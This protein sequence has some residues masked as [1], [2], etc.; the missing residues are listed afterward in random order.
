MFSVSF[1]S[2]FKGLAL[3]RSE[4]SDRSER[5]ADRLIRW[6]VF[7]TGAAKKT[8]EDEESKEHRFQL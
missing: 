2:R 5:S 8:V 3:E 7:E 6:L 4:R 1:K